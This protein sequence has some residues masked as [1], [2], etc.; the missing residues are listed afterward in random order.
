MA[1]EMNRTLNQRVME[2]V[3]NN[4]EKDHLM[5][6]Q[7]R[8]AGMGEMVGNIAHQWRQPLNSLGLVIQ[9]LR[10]AHERGEMDKAYLDNSVREGMELIRHMSLTIDD[11]RNFFRPNREVKEFNLK[12]AVDR[13]LSFVGK[14]FKNNNIEIETEVMEEI[15]LTGHPNEYSQVV[16]NILGNAK[17]ALLEG[18]VE[19]PMVRLRLFMEDG[20]SVLTISDNAGGIP[21][22]IMERIFDPYFTTKDEGRGTV[23]GLYMSK[24]IIEK[25]MGG[26]LTVRNINGG[27]EFRVE[28]PLSPPSIKR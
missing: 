18:R 16:L 9:D 11:F 7:S 24:A 8:L 10:A 14:S 23:I 22:E 20:S 12:D 17:E 28:V 25:H 5:I 27:A 13:A 2:E 6:Q 1:W 15:R 26:E 21:D 3:T 4:R 19:R